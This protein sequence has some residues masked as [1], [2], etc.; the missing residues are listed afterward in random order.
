MVLLQVEGLTA[1]ALGLLLAAAPAVRHGEATT[2]ADCNGLWRATRSLSEQ[3]DR[4]SG[5]EKVRLL[6][7]AIDAGEETVLRCPEQAEA[8]FWL[9]ASYGRLAEAKGGLTA[10]RMVGRIRREME[11]SIRLRPGYEGGDAFLALGRLDLSVP[12]LFGGN[13]TR[14]VE[15]LEEG[16]RVA[17]GNLEIRLALA[18]AYVH[19]RRRAEAEALLRSIVDTPAA[20]AAP[21]DTRREA[22]ELLRDLD[23]AAD[24]AS[25]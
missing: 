21:D 8:H 1:A 4:A 22:I 25:R 3:G 7:R 19:D 6:E 12:G 23:Q 15:R 11:A 9:G 13:R 10:L 24:D 2:S 20:G 18:Q 16:L 17:P 5:E 14:G